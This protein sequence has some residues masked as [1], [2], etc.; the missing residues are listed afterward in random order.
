MHCVHSNL[1]ARFTKK[2]ILK[3]SKWRSTLD[4]KR[5]VVYSWWYLLALSTALKFSSKFFR[6]WSFFDRNQQTL[7]NVKHLERILWA[8]FI[9]QCPYKFSSFL[10][11]RNGSCRFRLFARDFQQFRFFFFG[12]CMLFKSGPPR[13]LQRW[14]K[15]HGKL[16]VLE[17][18]FAGSNSMRRRGLNV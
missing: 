13:N 14:V 6:K 17:K 8:F 3:G 16:K 9:A 7:N 12:I 1:I 18:N 2:C 15:C 10:D 4:C 11:L 5:H